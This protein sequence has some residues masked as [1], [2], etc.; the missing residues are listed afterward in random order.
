MFLKTI[1]KIFPPQPVYAHCD[2]PCG[3]YDPYQ[4]QVAAHTVVRMVNLLD[5]VNA[6]SPE[7]D[8]DERK[9][10]IS[11]VARLTSVKEEHAE[12]VKREVR[13][14]WGDYFKPE[15]AEKFPNLHQLVF[16]IM[17]LASKARQEVNLEAA[18]QLLRKVQEFAEIF[19]T[20]KDKEPVRVKST[21][22]TEGELVLPK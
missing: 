13:I 16:D 21:Y 17:K 18:E 3:I 20:T 2:I 9:R 19:W 6:S 8:F 1:D 22:P 4:A 11:R 7:P 15:H 10:I 12:T 5:E 14:I